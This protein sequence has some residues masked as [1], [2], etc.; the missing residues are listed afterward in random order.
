MSFLKYNYTDFYCGLISG[1]VSNTVCN[2]FDVIRT[3][4][5]LGNKVQ[6]NFTFLSRGLLCRFYN[7]SNILVNL[8]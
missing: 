5:Q 2:P 4:K 8:F 3:N 1:L 6:Y 7:Y